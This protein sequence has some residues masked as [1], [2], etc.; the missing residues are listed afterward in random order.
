MTH[1][2]SLS[3]FRIRFA[4]SRLVQQKTRYLRFWCLEHHCLTKST[5][6]IPNS[7]VEFRPQKNFPVKMTDD[8]KIFSKFNRFSHVQNE[9]RKTL[10]DSPLFTESCAK[11]FEVHCMHTFVMLLP[12]QEKVNFTV[13]VFLKY[14]PSWQQEA[15]QVRLQQQ[16]PLLNYV[17]LPRHL[18]N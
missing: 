14:L 18:K 10:N 4:L 17:H 8:P 13:A 9:S 2:F 11:R 5:I 12:T 1:S 15:I 6:Q 7:T 3:R 16:S